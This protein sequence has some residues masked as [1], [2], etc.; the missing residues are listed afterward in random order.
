MSR[1]PRKSTAKLNPM[2]NGRKC[3]DVDAIRVKL[4][5][6]PPG[7]KDAKLIEYLGISAESFYKLKRGDEDFKFSVDYYKDV[8]TLAVLKSFTK[9]ACGFEYDEH[10]KELKKNKESGKLE[11]VVTKTVTKHVVPNAAA[12]YNYLKNRAPEHFKDK[13]ETEHKFPNLLENITFVIKG[14]DK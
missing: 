11:M 13:M 9:V 4:F 7:L 3:L 1:K 5:G 12:A 2:K 14:K 8:T 6:A 10:T